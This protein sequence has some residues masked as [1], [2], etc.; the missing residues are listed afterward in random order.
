MLDSKTPHA[1]CK[2]YI[3]IILSVL[4]IGDLKF[5]LNIQS[6]HVTDEIY[7]LHIFKK[8]VFACSAIIENAVLQ[9]SSLDAL[10]YSLPHSIKFLTLALPT[11]ASWAR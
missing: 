6:L 9:T 10:F 11:W 5:K 1:A 2:I 7:M 4:Y 3:Y 8:K